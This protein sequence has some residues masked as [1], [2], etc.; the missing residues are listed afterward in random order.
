MMSMEVFID[1]ALV[2]QRDGFDMFVDISRACWPVY[3]FLIL[4]SSTAAHRVRVVDID[5][6]SGACV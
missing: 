3:Y 2:S 5:R 4:S 1:I 6:V